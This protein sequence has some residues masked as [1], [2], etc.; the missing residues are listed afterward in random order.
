MRNPTSL[1]VFAHLADHFVPAGLLTLEQQG[2]AVLASEFAYGTK[3]LERSNALEIDPVSL[4]L[5]DKRQVR[6]QRLF[7][8]PDLNQFGG[9]RDAAPDA[10]GR[11]VIE[12][13]LQVPANSLPEA[14]YL[15]EAGSNRIGALDIRS[16]LDAKPRH[17][18][19]HITDLGYLLEAAERIEAGLPV[20]QQ[21]DAIFD[22]GSALGGARA[23]AT[24]RDADGVLWLAK[25]RSQG[26]TLNVPA[27]EAATLDLARRCGL[28]VP[29]LRLIEVNGRSV[30][31]IRRF[32]RYWANANDVASLTD[33]AE[34]TRQTE[35][36]PQAESPPYLHQSPGAGRLEQRLGFVSGLTLLACD[37]YSA[38][39]KSYGQLA[40]A[41]RQYCQPNLIRANCRE[42]FA[43]MVFNIFVNNDDDHLRNHGFL[44]YPWHKTG[45]RSGGWGLSPLYD[46][47]PRPTLA[48]DR[49]LFLGVGQQGRVATLDNAIS[50]HA[51]FGL[52]HAEAC[53]VIGRLWCE[54]R[55]WRVAFEAFG[56]LPTAIEAAASAFRHIDVL[57]SK[58]LRQAL[59]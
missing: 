3:Y 4:S 23:K 2:D 21:L 13:R 55:E 32:D 7:P 43:R 33:W 31:L 48:T 51:Q 45:Q 15:L 56:L 12:A 47:M 42:L 9:I 46:V 53:Q 57:A 8:P 34:L 18:L 6:Q 29:P 40:Q 36:A 30:M 37:E 50:A 26:E 17:G 19:S 27:I 49:H 11:R 41:I 20:P 14:R 54:L 39:Q 28:T 52:S 24:V 10:W 16:A 25:F 22:S 59:P 5:A 38:R 35:A 1:F 44:W 58:A